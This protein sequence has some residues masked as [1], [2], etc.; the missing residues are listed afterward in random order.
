M[1]INL[2]EY[3]VRDGHEAE[4]EQIYGSNG[5][6]AQLFMQSDGYLGTE[7]LRD[8]DVRWRYITIDRWISAEVYDTFQEKYRKAYEKLDARCESLTES[9][10]LIGKGELVS[11]T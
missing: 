4:F 11:S 1:Y 10:K 2:W 9:E 7:L 6:W 8:H 3:F 5:D